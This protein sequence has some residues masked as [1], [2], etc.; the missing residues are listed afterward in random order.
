MRS[1][2][3][4]RGLR[5]RA[6]PRS[7]RRTSRRTMRRRTSCLG[8][9][10]SWPP[11]LAPGTTCDSHSHEGKR[12][13]RAQQRRR[14][15]QSSTGLASDTSPALPMSSPARCRFVAWQMCQLRP[16]SR[17]RSLCRRLAGGAQAISS[18][19][20]AAPARA[21]P[22]LDLSSTPAAGTLGTGT[23]ARQSGV[24]RSAA[25]GTVPRALCSRH[26]LRAYQSTRLPLSGSPRPE[27][28]FQCVC[29]FVCVR[30]SPPRGALTWNVSSVPTCIAETEPPPALPHRH[31]HTGG[32]RGAGPPDQGPFWTAA[33]R[34]DTAERCEN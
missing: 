7:V 15:L 13:R 29:V 2:C 34:A 12:K 16:F 4:R 33:V 24:E 17:G 31:T 21:H 14:L 30:V 6:A 8:V 23:S 19:L 25:P 27:C 32:W 28:L 10:Q 20:A 18:C 5:W 26:Q 1:R 3:W 22:V 11:P 9:R